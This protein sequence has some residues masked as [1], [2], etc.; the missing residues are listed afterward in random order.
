M[1]LIEKTKKKYLLKQYPYCSKRQKVR[2]ITRKTYIINR[3][4]IKKYK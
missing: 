2:S 4:D 3:I 1:F